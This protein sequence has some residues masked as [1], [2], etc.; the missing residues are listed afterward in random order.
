MQS[1]SPHTYGPLEP[2]PPTELQD[3]VVFRGLGAGERFGVRR[4]GVQRMRSPGLIPPTWE[5]CRKSLG[6]SVSPILTITH[7]KTQFQLPKI[8]TLPQSPTSASVSHAGDQ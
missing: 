7:L 8:Q 1:I 6:I 4:F 3:Q 5:E 2:Q